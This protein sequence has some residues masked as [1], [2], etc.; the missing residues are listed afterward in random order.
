MKKKEKK[1]HDYLYILF[2]SQKEMDM[3]KLS[4][5][6]FASIRTLQGVAQSTN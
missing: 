4:T 2:L 3:G 5:F 6:G 1:L